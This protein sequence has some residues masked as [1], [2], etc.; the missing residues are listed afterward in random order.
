MYAA[1]AT[2]GICRG[3]ESSVSVA[4]GKQLSF[5]EPRC[6]TG[7]LSLMFKPMR[8]PREREGGR[9]TW[10]ARKGQLEAQMSVV[11]KT[12]ARPD[13]ARPPGKEPSSGELAVIMRD[14][15]AAAV[16][17][18]TTVSTSRVGLRVY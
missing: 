7:S 1:D 6:R 18:L 10:G 13:A 5:D 2:Q 11:S 9:C 15:R 12:V 8:N 17:R 3:H 16:P 14:Q 4:T